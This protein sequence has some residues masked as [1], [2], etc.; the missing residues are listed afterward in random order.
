[1]LSI[2]IPI[3][4]DV[5]TELMIIYKIRQSRCNRE[6]MEIVEINARVTSNWPRIIT[7]QLW[8]CRLR[9]LSILFLGISTA[10]ISRFYDLTS[11]ISGGK[12]YATKKI[13]RQ[14]NGFIT[15]QWS[16][17]SINTIKSVC[18]R[19]SSNNDFHVFAING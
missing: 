19:K 9:S 7:Q 16:E 10:R 5:C 13:T 4:R 8:N 17:S 1:M 12:D 18:E 6:S 11:C 3:Y 2:L 15:C 14:R